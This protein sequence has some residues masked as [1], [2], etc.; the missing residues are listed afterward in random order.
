MKYL[1][2]LKP[3]DKYFFGG[4]MTFL[5]GD[6]KNKDFDNEQYSSYIIE[7]N[8][9]PQQTSLLGMLRFLL[10]S[11]NNEAFDKQNNKIKSYPKANGLIGKNSFTVTDR[12]KKTGHRFE[13]IIELYPCFLQIEEKG[14]WYPLLPAPGDY[15]LSIEFDDSVQSNY[16][17]INYTKS[18]HVIGYDPKEWKEPL[19]IYNNGVLLESGKIFKQDVRIGIDKNYDGVTRKDD[20][21]FFKQIS[22]RLGSVE[23][24]IRFAF[25]TEIEDDIN[26][27]ESP[28]NNSIVTLGG[29]NSK[30]ILTVEAGEAI[31]Q[32]DEEYNDKSG[33]NC[34][35]KI[36]LL[37][38]AYLSEAEAN[39]CLFAIT[40]MVSFRFLTLVNPSDETDRDYTI[41]SNHL[42]R[43]ER[44]NL[45][46]K[47][48]VF[49]C[50]KEQ[51]VKLQ[52]ALESKVDFREIG[53]NYYQTINKKEYYGK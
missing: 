30:F 8:Q 23:K 53:Y 22:Y 46:K 15:G 43:S 36:V 44:F 19:F 52:Q 2:T 1:I 29:D 28:Y 50:D 24:P 38:D 5:V 3:I 12:K 32:Y 10:L 42:K 11:N 39:E 49:F 41:K 47:G 34:D 48:S 4:D 33:F 7:S 18:P 9:Y 37:S 45:Y 20:K 31:L 21:S 13:K 14:I 40:D 35:S 6:E 16:N 51:K 27:L 25:S 26:L 17:T